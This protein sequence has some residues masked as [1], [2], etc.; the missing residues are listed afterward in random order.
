MTSRSVLFLDSNTPETAEAIKWLKDQN[1]HVDNSDDVNIMFQK[2]SIVNFDIL[3]VNLNSMQIL[4][5]QLIDDILDKSPETDTIFITNEKIKYELKNNYKNITLHCLIEPVN[6][7]DFVGLIQYITN[8]RDSNHKVETAQRRLLSKKEFQNF[9]ANSK[10]MLNVIQFIKRNAIS[11]IP[12]VIQGERGVGKELLARII[13]EN[14][15]RN[16]HNFYFGDFESCKD[17]RANAELFGFENE[18]SKKKIGLLEM[19]NESTLFIDEICHL[20]P[21][22]QGK[23]ARFLESKYFERIGGDAYI[24]SNARLIVSTCKDLYKE[25]NNGRFKREL[26]YALVVASVSLPPLRERID[27]IPF[28]IKFFINKYNKKYKKE[29]QSISEEAQNLLMKYDY[30]EDNVRQLENII[31]NAIYNENDTIITLMAVK[32]YFE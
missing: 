20:K 21:N 6:L 23:L 22:T 17:T 9:I 28:L 24:K 29:I 25:M 5:K 11:D 12:I 8:N 3:L 16:N 26:Y 19:A 27:D 13:H 31:K 32:K 30:L 2:L 10:P 15:L 4:Y 14:S 18:T 7:K 1:Y